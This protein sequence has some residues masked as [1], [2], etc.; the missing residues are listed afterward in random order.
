MGRGR[1]Q[2]QTVTKPAAAGEAAVRLSATPVA[3]AGT[4]ARPATGTASTAPPGFAPLPSRVS[5][6]RV[7]STT[8]MS[9]A[10][11]KAP[12][13]STRRWVAMFDTTHTAP[14]ASVSVITRLG[15]VPPAV[16]FTFEVVPRGRSQGPTLTNPAAAAS[17]A[18][19]DSATAR[20]P[21]GTPLVA[22]TGT[23]T[24]V[25]PGGRP[26]LAGS[27]VSARRTGPTGTKPPPTGNAPVTSTTRCV[28]SLLRRQIDPSAPTGTIAAAATT[29]SRTKLALLA[30]GAGP[31]HPKAVRKPALRG[32]STVR[33]TATAVAPAG[34]P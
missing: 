9:D 10:G 19:T 21:A 34:T 15:A 13:R 26:V 14:V 18:V 33:F 7:A 4:P 30:S 32:R 12:R 2:G 28:D 27:R 16:T 25:P 11:P 22:A 20:A 3:S 17:V 8:P 24:T 6:S 31:P 29:W 1:S 23:R 5:S